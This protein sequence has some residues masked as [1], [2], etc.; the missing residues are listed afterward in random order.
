VD[1]CTSRR[2]V[3]GGFRDPARMV[4]L[5]R[6][7]D[8]PALAPYAEHARR[9]AGR[10]SPARRVHRLDRAAAEGVVWVAA[11]RAGRLRGT[12]Q[13]ARSNSNAA[14]CSSWASFTRMISE[15]CPR[16]SSIR[17]AA[18]EFELSRLEW[19]PGESAPVTLEQGG[20]QVVIC[21]AGSITL[22]T[23]DDGELI[24][25]HGESVWSPPPTGRSTWPRRVTVTAARR[26][27]GR[28]PVESEAAFRN[29]IV[30]TRR[31]RSPVHA[32]SPTEF[33]Q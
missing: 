17:T 2:S 30:T 27:S 11:A 28:P 19:A 4:E 25:T 13:G 14:P 20:P 10:R 21:L 7:L 6:A 1:R 22:R 26:H 3:D 8:V 23:H 18:P 12:R 24:L 31:H 33:R 29:V 32:S 9:P 16:C 15:Y 5:L